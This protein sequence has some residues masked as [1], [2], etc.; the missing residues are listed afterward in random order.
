[1]HLAQIV[2]AQDEPVIHSLIDEDLA[3]HIVRCV[4]RFDELVTALRLTQ[5]NL[6][7]LAY[8]QPLKTDE[9]DKASSQTW[10]EVVQNAIARAREE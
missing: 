7:A 8:M 6:D 9:T 5:R 10:R 2:D 4:N 3:A 1:M